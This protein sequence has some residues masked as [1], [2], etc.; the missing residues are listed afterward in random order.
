[1]LQGIKNKIQLTK[2]VYQ[3]N[4]DIFFESMTRS[5][6]SF[7]DDNKKFGLILLATSP[8]KAIQLS[9]NQMR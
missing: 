5:P 8:L 1:M 4:Q 6:L 2:E 3:N 9:E 7:K